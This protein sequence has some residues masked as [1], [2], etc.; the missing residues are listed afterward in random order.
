MNSDNQERMN[1]TVGTFPLSMLIMVY[2]IYLLTTYINWTINDIMRLLLDNLVETLMVVTS[3]GYLL[4]ALR[5][6][7]KHLASCIP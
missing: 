4:L 2:T 7:K 1:G 5:K 6:A 3:L